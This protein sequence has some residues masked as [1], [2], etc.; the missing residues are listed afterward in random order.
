MQRVLPR[1]IAKGEVRLIFFD[2]FVLSRDW[3]EGA[4]VVGRVFRDKVEE[5]KV[6][7]MSASRPPA[8]TEAVECQQ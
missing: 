7:D 5:Q 3:P 2:A 8:A 4:A 1:R 6:R